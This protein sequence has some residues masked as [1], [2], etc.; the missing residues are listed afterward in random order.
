[1]A[2]NMFRRS[3]QMPSDRPQK[4]TGR[5]SE[6]RPVPAQY[7]YLVSYTNPSVEGF[8]RTYVTRP[9]PIRTENDIASIEAAI[10][11]SNGHRQIVLLAFS[12]MSGPQRRS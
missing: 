8:G 7:T 3:R 9:A 6:S 11:R 12:L 2:D 4:G 1:M 10:G 5:V